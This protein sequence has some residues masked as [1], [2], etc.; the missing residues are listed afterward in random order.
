[1]KEVTH[2]KNNFGYRKT[3][4]TVWRLCK[5]LPLPHPGHWTLFTMSSGILGEGIL[6]FHVCLLLGFSPPLPAHLLMTCN[7]VEMNCSTWS[8][9]VLSIGVNGC[10]NT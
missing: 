7:D 2:A 3:F 9:Q 4:D 5:V 1:M 10:R 8:L 6:V